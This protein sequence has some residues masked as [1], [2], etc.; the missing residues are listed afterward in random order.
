M[1][2][3]AIRRNRQVTAKTMGFVLLILFIFLFYNLIITHIDFSAPQ[4]GGTLRMAH[5][6]EAAVSIALIEWVPLM[7]V[8]RADMIQTL[9]EDFI[10]M[11]RAKGMRPGAPCCATPSNRLP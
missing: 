2:I 10:L 9:K 11:A 6:L 1:M 7:R 8:L 4:C 5:E 3:I